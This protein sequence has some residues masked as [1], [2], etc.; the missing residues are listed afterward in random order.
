MKVK[1]Q[2]S[3]PLGQE[4]TL[5]A[6]KILS[7]PRLVLG[8]LYLV[9][10]QTPEVRGHSGSPTELNPKA[11]ETL[12]PRSLFALHSGQTEGPQCPCA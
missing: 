12:L 10:L 5:D 7:N 9:R 3:C 11:P 4:V 8:L 1:P 2:K 6:L